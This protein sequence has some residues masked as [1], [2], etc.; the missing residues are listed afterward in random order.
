M[1]SSSPLGPEQDRDVYEF[2]ILERLRYFLRYENLMREANRDFEREDD[3]ATLRSINRLISFIGHH[4][5][6]RE[7]L[8]QLSSQNELLD[9]FSASEGVD[10]DKLSQ[11]IEK[12]EA[13]QRHFHEF[14]ISLSNYQNHP[15][16]AGTMRQMSLHSGNCSFDLP[17]L[18]A[19]RRLSR[20]ARTAMLEEWLAPMREFSEGIDICL[21][22]TRQSGKFEALCA[23]QGYFSMTPEGLNPCL[24]C[25]RIG[26]ARPYYPIISAG[27]Q[28]LTAHFMDPG[29]F[30]SPPSQTKEDVD[31]EMACCV[32]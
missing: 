2:P 10:A 19:W 11:W 15:F 4:D 12:N 22:L 32:I 29:D 27:G 30:L 18:L 3:I 9:R 13:A 31:F 25:L 8:H 6:K 5:L 20:E 7:L 23:K 21:A 14:T 28:L 24:V 16:L 26:G 17:E 1:S